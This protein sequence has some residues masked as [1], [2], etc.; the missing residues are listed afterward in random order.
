M[1]AHFP[2]PLREQGVC[3]SLAHAAGSAHLFAP[4][5]NAPAWVWLTPYLFI[6]GRKIV[7]LANGSS[8]GESPVGASA[9]DVAV[10]VAVGAFPYGIELKVPSMRIADPLEMV[11][12]GVCS[13]DFSRCLH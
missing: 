9:V 8:T 6:S 4:K 13:D 2:N 3:L 10:G 7:L 11:C 5:R 12:K 1:G